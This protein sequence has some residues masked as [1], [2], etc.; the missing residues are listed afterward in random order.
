MTQSGE[1]NKVS[2]KRQNMAQNLN[3]PS[4]SDSKQEVNPTE[5]LKA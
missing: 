5:S 4:Q 2:G 3:I 1:Q